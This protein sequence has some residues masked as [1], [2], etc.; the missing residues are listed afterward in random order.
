[1]HRLR[2]SL[3]VFFIHGMILFNCF[4]SIPFI[5]FSIS[6]KKLVVS[7]NSNMKCLLLHAWS[8]KQAWKIMLAV[9]SLEMLIGVRLVVSTS[10][11]NSV[12][13]KNTYTWTE[14]LISPS[15]T[16]QPLYISSKFNIILYA[17]SV[18]VDSYI[19]S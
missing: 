1:M 10:I 7:R 13:Y 16:H 17:N 19:I 6:L 2:C 4:K 18:N 3:Y 14:Y 9:P 15:L 11:Q 5:V 12:Y 8:C